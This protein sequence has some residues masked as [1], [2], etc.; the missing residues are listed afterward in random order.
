MSVVICFMCKGEGG[1]WYMPH[2]MD[3]DPN[4]PDEPRQWIK[5]DHCKGSGRM[6]QSHS[7]FIP[8]N[9]KQ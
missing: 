2:P 1:D 8:R 6:M 5:C 9:E 4:A 3:Y 7:A